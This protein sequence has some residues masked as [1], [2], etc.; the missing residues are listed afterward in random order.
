[1]SALLAVYER[2]LV[3]VQG[4]GRAALRQGRDE[5]PRLRG[6][7]RRERPR[8]RRP[9]RCWPPSASR[10]GQLIHAS[11]LYHNEPASSTGRA[12]RPPGLPV[13][14]VLLQLRHRG[15]GGG[16]SSSRARSAGRRAAPSSSRFE[17]AF[18]GRTHGRALAHLDREV[19][20]ALRAAG[21]GRALL[22]WNDLDA[23][24]AAIADETAAVLH[25][26]GA[27]RGRR[28]PARPRVPARP[29]RA[30]P[31]AR[32]AARVRRGPV[33]PRPHG[34]ACSRTSTRGSRPTS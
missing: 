23:V 33:R 31:R 8:L 25:R 20:R 28:P 10:P 16:A 5:L 2:D 13:Q 11:N 24:G 21:A 29:A 3:L 27:G 34:Q 9:A 12:P 4:Q 7:H 30:L 6:R 32:R 26:A 17:R 18:H 15:V 19:P 1:M 14:G 22:P